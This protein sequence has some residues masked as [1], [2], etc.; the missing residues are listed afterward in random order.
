MICFTLSAVT[1]ATLNNT[2]CKNNTHPS[3][4]YALHSVKKTATTYMQSTYYYTLH[5]KIQTTLNNKHNTK[6]CKLH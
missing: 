5:L 1:H 6:Y 3:Q 4:Q 2:H